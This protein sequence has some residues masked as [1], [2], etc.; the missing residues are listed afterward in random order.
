[1]LSRKQLSL[2]KLGFRSVRSSTL[3][4]DPAYFSG[5]VNGLDTVEA[6]EVA[7]LY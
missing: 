2:L 7:E 3:K 1:M 5:K 4:R 6:L